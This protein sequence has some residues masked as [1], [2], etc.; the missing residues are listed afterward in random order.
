MI[1]NFINDKWFKKITEIEIIHFQNT[2]KI[3]IVYKNRPKLVQS[4]KEE[5]IIATLK[6]RPLTVEDIDNMF[7]LE[8]KLILNQLEKNGLIRLID[9]A[10]IKFYKY[11][12]K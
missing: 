6:R 1:Y 11:F 5:E 2:G 3:N 4:Y 8:A 9:N 12:D 10:G 7:D